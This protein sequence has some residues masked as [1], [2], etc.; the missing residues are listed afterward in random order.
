MLVAALR[1]AHRVISIV[2]AL[3]LAAVFALGVLTI[4][5]NSQERTL[6]L[7]SIFAEKILPVHSRTAWFVERGMPYN[8]TVARAAGVYPPTALADDPEFSQ[9]LQSSGEHTY[10]VFVVQHP[11]Y[12]F[13]GPL[14]YLSGEKTSLQVASPPTN[15]PQVYPVAS[16][17]SPTA[18]YGRHREVL[19]S[20]LEGLWFEQGQIGDVIVLAVLAVSVNV[21]AWRR[22]G[23]DGRLV[24]PACTAGL[25][26]VH[27]Y[28][29]WLTSAPPELDRQAMAQAVALRIALWIA[30]ACGV[31]R[32]LA[33]RPR[34]G[35]HTRVGAKGAG[36]GS[37]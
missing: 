14:P 34:Q 32:L 20:V 7:A 33:A 6:N 3:V 19:P 10:L 30:L 25:V 17:L 22:S 4:S 15:T 2:M 31:D 11:G 35:R 9:W 21:A 27:H 13:L 5:R 16:M 23:R 24:V 26:L 12:T 18:N 28:F 37:G 29:V 8:L 1:S 36:A